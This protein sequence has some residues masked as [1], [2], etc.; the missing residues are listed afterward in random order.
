VDFVCE[1]KG[2]GNKRRERES[3]LVVLYHVMYNHNHPS[4]N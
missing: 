1:E 2:E 4:S 3:G